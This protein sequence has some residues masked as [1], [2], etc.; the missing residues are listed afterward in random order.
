MAL[1]TFVR[2]SPAGG[3]PVSSR[4]CATRGLC[5]AVSHR[6]GGG[7]SCKTG[8]SQPKDAR[9]AQPLRPSEPLENKTRYVTNTFS[10][11]AAEDESDF[12]SS[13]D[14]RSFY[15]RAWLGGPQTEPVRVIPTA[16]APRAPSASVHSSV[17]ASIL[18]LVDNPSLT[19]APDLSHTA[20]PLRYPTPWRTHQPP[21]AAQHG[22]SAG[23][24]PS[25]NDAT[26]R[27]DAYEEIPTTD[28]GVSSQAMST[29]PTAASDGPSGRP[30]SADTAGQGLA[31]ASA[32]ALKGR[33]VYSASEDRTCAAGKQPEGRFASLAAEELSDEYREEEH[34]PVTAVSQT[35]S[36]QV[37]RDG[38]P[39]YAELY[40]QRLAVTPL[41]S[42]EENAVLK[43]W[44]ELF[45]EKA[46]CAHLQKVWGIPLFFL[47]HPALQREAL[48]YLKTELESL[49][50]RDPNSE[51]SAGDRRNDNEFT[52]DTGAAETAAREPE[53]ARPPLRRQ[54]SFYF[55]H[56]DA[57]PG[58]HAA[59]ARRGGRPPMMIAAEDCL[60]DSCSG[61]D[62]PHSLRDRQLRF[63]LQQLRLVASGG[64]PALETTPRTTVAE[65]CGTPNT[66][67][68]SDGHTLSDRPGVCGETYKLVRAK[69]RKKRTRFF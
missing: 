18:S 9:T 3:Y 60:T 51:P 22:T 10:C 55:E 4:L 45:E 35:E 65:R 12:S 54:Q 20:L 8:A 30:P 1:R 62:E 23:E 37:R 41:T 67:R 7:R 19:E 43:A 21:H 36:L 33:G 48:S 24:Q 27:V 5:A 52:L 26:S 2:A 44:T 40:A 64:V 68:P 49:A 6:R 47:R 15:P 29:F 58:L 38:A 16:A 59:N 39:L 69:G 53:T 31:A 61:E 42:S 11:A 13:L 34:F 46:L 14:S 32:N 57:I 66:Q 25:P 28:S 17:S 50:S 56:E 63:L